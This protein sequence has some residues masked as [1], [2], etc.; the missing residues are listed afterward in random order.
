M[1]KTHLEVKFLSSCDSEKPTTLHASKL[2]LE[3]DV[4]FTLPGKEKG[5][6][7]GL[8]HPRQF[9]SLTGQVEQG[10]KACY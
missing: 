4:S 6:E 2:Q 5:K 8:A 1:D 7:K 10:I 3:I 9:L